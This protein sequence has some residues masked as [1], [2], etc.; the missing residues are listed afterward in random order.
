M[1]NRLSVLAALLTWAALF[2]AA[3]LA[4]GSPAVAMAVVVG[5]K[6]MR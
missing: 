2:S 3:W 1:C 5:I 4:S 6:V